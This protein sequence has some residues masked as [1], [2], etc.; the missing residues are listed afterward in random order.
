MAVR[1]NATRG[2]CVIVARIAVPWVTIYLD[3]ATTAD[4]QLTS[5]LA[6]AESNCILMALS[7]RRLYCAMI[8]RHRFTTQ[9]DNVFPPSP[10][11]PS[12]WVMLYWVGVGD[13]FCSFNVVSP[14]RHIISFV[15]NIYWTF[16][17][18][19]TEV[20]GL[21]QGYDGNAS[22][23]CRCSILQ[24]K[25]PRDTGEVR[26]CGLGV[27]FLRL[28]SSHGPFPE[29]ITEK[30]WVRWRTCLVNR[31]CDL[32]FASRLSVCDILNTIILAKNT[33]FAKLDDRNI[34]VCIYRSFATTVSQLKMCDFSGETFKVFEVL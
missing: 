33:M 5:P 26:A 30:Q 13:S 27:Q 10:S 31:K 25:L 9:G 12:W 17:F 24:S 3:T 16:N 23:L 32:T 29:F 19:L 15:P 7:S 4:K 21:H 1:C 34:Y 6:D 22:L 28:Q 18:A 11:R 20:G 2:T 14:Y 8:T